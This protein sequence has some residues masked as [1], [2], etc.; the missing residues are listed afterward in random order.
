MKIYKNE[1]EGKNILAT[2]DKLVAAWGCDVKE[3][4]VST[5]YGT[6]HVIEWGDEKAK[7]LILFHG[8]GDDSALMWLF[9]AKYLGQHYHLYAIDTLGGPGKSRPNENYNKNFD[10]IRWIDQVLDG[11]NIEKAFFAGVSNGGYLTQYY[12]LN[13]PEKVLKGICISISVPSGKRKGLIP[14]LFKVFLPEALFPTVKNVEKLI[15]KLCGKNYDVFTDNKLIMAHYKSLLRGFNNMAMTYHKVRNFSEQEINSIRDKVV[16]LVGEEDPF[17]KLGGREA[18]LEN[19][20]EVFFYPDAGHGLN[21][22]LADEIN[23]KIVEHL[24]MYFNS[25]YKLCTKENCVNI[26][27]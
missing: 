27:F 19:R 23:K 11:L 15:K 3:Y 10:D 5:D 6:T 9:N 13:R 26:F 22:E 21:H 20:M 25:T 8:V 7:P 4:D 14:P 17:Q 1:I 2:Y 24:A 18:L 16:Y 12:T